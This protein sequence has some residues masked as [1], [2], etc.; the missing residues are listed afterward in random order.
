MSDPKN[1]HMIS[2]LQR[3]LD[4]LEIKLSQEL[5]V[6]PIK[7]LPVNAAVRSRQAPAANQSLLPGAWRD[8][9]Q[10]SRDN[11]AATMRARQ[12]LCSHSNTNLFITYVFRTKRFRN[13][14]PNTRQNSI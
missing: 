9:T 1:S 7:R 10:A 12:G 6:D 3:R 5:G 14:V 11:A 2:E 13:F 8:R 4:H